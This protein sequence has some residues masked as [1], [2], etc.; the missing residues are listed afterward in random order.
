MPDLDSRI[1]ETSLPADEATHLTRVL[2]LETGDH[3]AVFDGRGHEF[4]AQVTSTAKRK[5]SIELLEPIV[6]AA[7]ARVP[8]TLVQA[9]LKGDKMDA[10]VRDAT[11][12]GVAAIEPVVTERTIARV[13]RADNDRWMR[14]SIASAKQCRR[15]VIPVISSPRP[16]EEWLRSS[17]HGLRLILVEPSASTGEGCSLHLLENHAAGSLALMVGP[18]G[19]WTSNERARAEEA[20]CLSVTLGGLTL[21]ADA[22]AL[23]VL[24]IARFALKDL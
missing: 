23:A 22:V 4:R 1:R 9:V 16:F 15:A 14:V 8:I 2:R 20:G 21:R 10:V 13:P 19:G 17:G 5:V 12:M 18:E 24:G 11:M 3:I 7:E 6:P